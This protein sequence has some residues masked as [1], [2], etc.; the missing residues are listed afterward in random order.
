MRKEFEALKKKVYDSYAWIL[1]WACL[2]SFVRGK[3]RGLIR[4]IIGS[5]CNFKNE[6]F[7]QINERCHPTI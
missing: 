3:H 6:G 4:F 1:I 7:Y 5:Y 2:K